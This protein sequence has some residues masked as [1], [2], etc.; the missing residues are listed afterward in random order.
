MTP[1]EEAIDRLVQDWL[2]KAEEDFEV[3]KYLV[4]RNAPY[5]SAIGFHAQQAAEKLLKALLTRLQVYFPKTHDLDAI[6]DLLATVNEPLADSLRDTIVLSIYGVEVR[7]PGDLVEMTSEDAKTALAL[8]GKIRDA[9]LK[10][11]KRL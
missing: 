2:H 11:L 7:Y 1:P 5:P 3:A 10:E 4:S 8:A 9:A 6:L